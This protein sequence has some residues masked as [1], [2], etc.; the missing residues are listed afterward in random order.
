MV[1]DGCE[2]IFWINV[3][4]ELN[5]FVDGLDVGRMREREKFKLILKFLIGKSEWWFFLLSVED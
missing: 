2:D 1:R 3:G 4:V 5:E